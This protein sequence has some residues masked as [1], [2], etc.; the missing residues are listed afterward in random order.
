MLA[1]THLHP[2]T[3]ID[4][5]PALAPALALAQAPAPAQAGSAIDPRQHTAPY[6]DA[7]RSLANEDW[8]RL[9]VPAH[10]GSSDHAPGLGGVV[11]EDALRIDFPM[12]F[13]GIDQ[14]NWRMVNHSRQT[15]IVQAQ[16]LAAEAWGASR[17]W[18]ITNGASGG[19][20]IATTVVRGLGREFVLQRSVHSSVI[21]GITHA[22]LRPHFVHGRVDAGLGSSHGVTPD[23]VE[24][25]LTEHPDSSAVYLVSPS[26]FGAVADIAAIAEVAHRHDVPLIVDE[27]WGS[28]LGMHSRLPVNAVRCGA[29][30]VISSTHK[31]AGSLT[32]SAMV[33]LGHGP[34]AQRI[35]T[36]VDRVVK[37]YQSTSTSALLLAS[38]DEARRHLVT[39]PEAIE[40]ALNTAEEIR[41]RVQND[42]RFRD[43]TPDILDGHDA[44][45]NDPFKVVIDTRGAGIT[46]SEAQYQLIRD[47]RIYCELAT[48]SALLLLIGATSP[49]DVDRFWTALQSLPQSE[50]EPE[51]PIVLPGSC[52]KAMEISD[53]YFAQTRTVP[54]AEA[55]GRVSADSLAAYPPGVPNVLPGEVLSA[56]VVSF[57]RMTADAPS[58]Y[59][60]GAQDSTMDTFRIVAHDSGYR[61][62]R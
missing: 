23:Q 7:V 21:D 53:A 57:L 52:E 12:L 18:F 19:N 33:Q 56:E 50:V 31:G 46:G 48:P 6:A 26:Y 54:F 20:H 58:G 10:Q 44:I 35:E 59:V 39:H 61:N 51:R 3:T 15:P 45:A 49:V 24:A 40:A 1:E 2:D 43:A 41:T 9:H 17:A 29:D 16:Q 60:R 28:H 47:H 30:L 32:Q 5:T 37:S 11:G 38:L 22:D 42:A 36:L 27:A 13:S 55:I 8:L 4:S 62:L 25:A 34:Q 14:D